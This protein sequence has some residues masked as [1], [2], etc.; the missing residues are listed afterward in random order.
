MPNLMARCVGTAAGRVWAQKASALTA[1][2]GD[3]TCPLCCG[4]NLSLALGLKFFQ[5]ASGSK[6]TA[7][8]SC[9]IF[10]PPGM[11][12]RER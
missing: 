2:T 5:E 8:F 1:E 12:G 7:F 6:D 4:M 10:C 11:A 9:R 3:S